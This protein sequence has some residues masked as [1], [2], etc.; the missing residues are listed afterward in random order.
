MLYPAQRYVTAT[1]GSVAAV[2][3]ERHSASVHA[4]QHKRP[5]VQNVVAVVHVTRKAAVQLMVKNVTSVV[6]IITLHLCVEV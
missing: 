6:R 5:Q 2:Q 1:S 4:V 3:H